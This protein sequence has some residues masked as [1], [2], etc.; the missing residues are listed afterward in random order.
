MGWSSWIAGS[1]LLVALVGPAALAA[2]AQRRRW[3]PGWR[4]AVACLADVVGATS[5]V[6]GTAQLL[7]AAGWFRALPLVLVSGVVSVV[8]VAT[9]QRSVPMAHEVVPSADVPD[10]AKRPARWALVVTV[11]VVSGQW[12]SYTVDSL[13]AGITAADSLWYHLPRAARF[14]Q[15]GWLTRLHQTAPEFPDAFHP[16]TGELVQALPML[17]YQRDAVSPLVNLG[18]MAMLLLAAWCVGRPTGRAELSTL[19]VAAL[20]AAPLVVVEGAGNAGNDIA[21]MAFLLA[22]VAFVLQPG[23][24]TPQLALAGLA[25]GL[26]ISTKLT[27][28]PA[29]AMLTVG[30]LWAG[31]PG[32]RARRVLAWGIGLV[33]T[34][35]YWYLRNLLIAGSPVPSTDLPL[36]GRRSFRIADE[37]GFSV[38]DYLTDG[39]VWREWLLPGLRAD[40]GWAWPA[41]AAATVWVVVGAWRERED[42]FVRSLALLVPVSMAAYI[43]L[44]TTAL[45]ER[46]QPILFAGNVIYLVPVLALVLAVLPTLRASRSPTLPTL[47]MA[48]CGAVVAAGAL[49]SPISTIAEGRAR[50]ALGAAAL[51]GLLGAVVVRGVPRPP[52]RVLS[53]LVVGVSAMVLGVGQRVADRYLDG[54]YATVPVSQWA[55]SVRGADL[56][57]AGFAGQFPLYG[58]HLDNTVTY[59][60]EE[61][62]NGE[63]HDMPSC[64]RWRAAL[65]AG[66]YEY[67]VLRSERSDITDRQL[68]WTAS[69]PAATPVLDDPGGT[70]FRFDSSVPDPGC[71]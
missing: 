2:R 41:L 26:A 54:R 42:R 33:A 36:F 15:T 37:L 25:A 22:A 68:A 28:V 60:G 55:A 17:M 56:A 31:R 19:C 64:P 52:R 66:R 47:V 69:D 32:E 53:L 29:V 4:G 12:V 18:W 10:D 57:I 50:V 14:A 16:S 45:G 20:L 23:E 43:T 7:G 62:S 39:R 34:G 3:L 61:R 67:V 27:V 49:T 6:V 5:V 63:F 8:L 35:I 38:A 44:P 51:V 1:L 65:R 11:A 71:A 48:G 30:I 59:V 13:R 21:A 46:G 58:P 9:G 24:T 40:F 70:V